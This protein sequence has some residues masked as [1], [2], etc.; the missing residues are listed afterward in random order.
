MKIE[1]IPALPPDVYQYQEIS[2]N[3]PDWKERFLNLIR[4]KKQI[5]YGRY[6]LQEIPKEIEIELIENGYKDVVVKGDIWQHFLVP[7]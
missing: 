7:G 6:T 3:S 4:Q 1:V 5:K 2:A